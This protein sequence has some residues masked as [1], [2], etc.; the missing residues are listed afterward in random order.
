M[1]KAA[2]IEKR[3]FVVLDLFLPYFF[4]TLIFFIPAGWPNLTDNWLLLGREMLERT[5]I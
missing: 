3:F 4:F 1:E 5:E 2:K